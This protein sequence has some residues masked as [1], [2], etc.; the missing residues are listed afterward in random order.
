MDKPICKSC[1][2]TITGIVK[3]VTYQKKVGK[4]LLNVVEYY[5]TECFK[6]INKERALDEHR[7]EKRTR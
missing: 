5:D 2:K 4:K 7:K 1:G 6:K 3:I